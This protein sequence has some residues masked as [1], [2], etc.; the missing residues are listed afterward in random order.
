MPRPPTPIGS[1]PPRGPPPPGGRAGGGTGSGTRHR[2][3]APPRPR[4]TKEGPM[5]EDAAL[6]VLLVQAVEQADPDGRVFTR[7]E[8]AQASRDARDAGGDPAAGP[9]PR[10]AGPRSRAGAAPGPPARG[11]RGPPPAA[12]R[13]ARP[14]RGG[15]GGGG[16]GAGRK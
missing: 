1:R 11:R 6:T 5:Q 14:R 3:G 15:G 8:R 10:R 13:R 7:A 4:R 12:G 2:G 9:A 16:G